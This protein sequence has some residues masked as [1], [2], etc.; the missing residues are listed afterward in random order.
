MRNPVLLAL[1]SAVLLI[2]CSSED[3]PAAGAA[4]TGSPQ[5]EAP[6]TD[7][8]TPAATPASNE[9]SEGFAPITSRD[10]LSGGKAIQAPGAT[11]TL[12]TSWQSE[13]PSS[14]MRLAQAKIPGDAGEGQL[15]VFHFGPGGGGGVEANLQRWI[16]QVELESEPQRESFTVGT[17]TVTWVDAM[18]TIKPSTM[19]VGPDTPQPG[20]RLLGAV[21]EGQGGPWFFK[22]TGPADTLAAER[23]AF[24][25]MLK[26][27][28]PNA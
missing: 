3:P 14:S 24:L 1:V 15:T 23:D 18:G 26:S 8:S 13:Q 5:A 6:N 21:V 11:F 16:G 22:A 2:A 7:G 27:A 4:E 20:S 9:G 28:Q 19:G 12:P 25:D 17:F 10:R